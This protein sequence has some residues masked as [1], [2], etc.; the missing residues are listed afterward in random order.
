MF[1]LSELSAVAAAHGAPLSGAARVA[2][3]ETGRDEIEPR[4]RSS[5]AAPDPCRFQNA[6]DHP[7]LPPPKFTLFSGRI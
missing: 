6:R 1:D 5:A 2:S 3:R 4:P 7:R